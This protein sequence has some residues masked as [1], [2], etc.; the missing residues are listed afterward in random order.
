MVRNVPLILSGLALTLAIL[1][2]NAAS[3]STPSPAAALPTLAASP[4][5]SD[6]PAPSV[7]DTPAA[8]V[9]AAQA[10]IPPFLT[11]VPGIAATLTAAFSTPGMESTLAAGQTQAAGTQAV[12]AP[13]L[14]SSLLSGCPHPSDPPQPSWLN[15]PVMPQVAA[16]Q[17][18]KTLVGSYYCFRAPVTVQALEDFYKQALPPP[19]WVLESDVNGTMEFIGL[20]QAGAQLV[21]IVSAPG[22]QNDLLVALN[23]TRPISIPTP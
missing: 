18:V 6:M 4:V 11:A 8:A 22:D 19:Q 2:C 1:A 3:P 9:T 14:A 16:G 7:T 12:L 13:Q 21:A 23:V 20:S 5:P 17:E 15:I 10:T